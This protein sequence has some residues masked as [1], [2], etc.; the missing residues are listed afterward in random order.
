M[1]ETAVNNGF[2]FQDNFVTIAALEPFLIAVALMVA[3]LHL[4]KVPND[5][6]F[7]NC[8]N[9]MLFLLPILCYLGKSEHIEEHT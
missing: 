1:H 8:R 3:V 5:T 7:A 6:K 4:L 2:V 9:K